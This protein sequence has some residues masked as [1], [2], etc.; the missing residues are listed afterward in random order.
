ML[1][2]YSYLK[3]IVVKKSRPIHSVAICMGVLKLYG[4]GRSEAYMYMYA[5]LRGPS[6]IHRV[7]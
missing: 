4:L 1:C 3:V 7:S 6:L 2:V 5:K